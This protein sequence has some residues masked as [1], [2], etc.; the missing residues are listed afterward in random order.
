[1]GRWGG[2][3]P[4]CQAARQRLQSRCPHGSIFTSLLL[5]AQIL[6]SSNVESMAQYSRSCSWPAQR[7]GG[8]EGEVSARGGPVGPQEAS[9]K[10]L[11][12]PQTLSQLKARGS[13]CP[14]M[15]TLL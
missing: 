14:Y 1:M 2:V 10:P 8:W 7:W 13:S 4:T 12:Q 5:S 11:R 6:Q 9:P 15:N 3:G